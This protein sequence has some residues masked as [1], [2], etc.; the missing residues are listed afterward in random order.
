[1]SGVRFNARR[2]SKNRP[3][4]GLS[5]CSFDPAFIDISA[6]LGIDIIW[7]EMEHANISMS[8]AESLCR[9]INANQMLSL[10]RLPCGNRDIVLRAA[11]SG[12]DMLML[13]M[14]NDAADLRTF[15]NHARYAPAGGRGFHKLSRSM[16]FGFGDSV[17]ELCRQ[18]NDNLML[19][20]QVE[21]LTALRNL[22]ELCEVDGIDGLFAGPGDLSSAYGA[23]GDT[24]DQRVLD[25]VST[26]IASSHKFA[27]C[28]GS[29][30]APED[31]PRWMPHRID[32]LMVG[33]NLGFYI[34]AGKA[35]R[36]E[37]GRAFEA[38]EGL[39]DNQ[40]P[41]NDSR[42]CR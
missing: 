17:S 2:A 37:L 23:P 18:A 24:A 21:T 5:L 29:A 35:L 3:L 36:D 15:V 20:G 7:I 8:E 9:A 34:S 38:A 25:A 30:A 42:I 13:P 14:V 33:N 27:K 12:V 31:V 11:E 32:M 41:M 6:N 26:T 16:N 1:M 40:L 4:I 10:I 28:A 39:S 19:W 22:P